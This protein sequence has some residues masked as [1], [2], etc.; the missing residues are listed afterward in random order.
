MDPIY[1]KFYFSV[2]ANPMTAKIYFRI[3]EFLQNINLLTSALIFANSKI[4][5]NLFLEMNS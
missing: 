3:R 1:A 5:E 4:G 2:S